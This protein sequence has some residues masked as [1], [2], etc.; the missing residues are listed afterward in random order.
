MQSWTL[1]YCFQ[2]N[3]LM[4]ESFSEPI[5]DQ[6]LTHAPTSTMIE[7]PGL[8]WNSVMNSKC[9]ASKTLRVVLHVKEGTASIQELKL[10]KHTFIHFGQGRRRCRCNFNYFKK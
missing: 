5:L 10:D 7:V 4:E 2:I 8:V 9:E 3:L 6:N 1:E